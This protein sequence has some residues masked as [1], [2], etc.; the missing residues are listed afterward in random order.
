MTTVNERILN[1]R[2][3]LSLSRA[4]FGQALGVSGDVIK[5]LDYNLTEPKPAFIDLLCR[6]YNVNRAWLESGEGEMFGQLGEDE[7]LAMIFGDLLSGE[8]DE[9]KVNLIKSIIEIVKSIPD[10]ALP[11]VAEYAQQVADAINKKESE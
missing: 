2:K 3:H 4:A 11:V 6:T 1:V 5:N 8:M 7:E 9:R 10:L